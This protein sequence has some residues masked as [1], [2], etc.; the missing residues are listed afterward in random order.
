VAVS[1]AGAWISQ[2]FR[3]GCRWYCLIAYSVITVSG[4]EVPPGR[5]LNVCIA[6][7]A[8]QPL[9]SVQGGRTLSFGV[10]PPGVDWRP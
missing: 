2:P 9:L 4:A 1:G 7:L 6:G 5:P 8:R 3:L 10:K